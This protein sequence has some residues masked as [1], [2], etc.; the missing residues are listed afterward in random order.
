MGVLQLFS[1]AVEFW[2]DPRCFFQMAL[3]CYKCPDLQACSAENIL[4]LVVSSCWSWCQGGYW[5]CLTPGIEL[6]SASGP[7]FLPS[8]SL[9][10]FLGIFV[11]F[12][13]YQTENLT[14]NFSIAYDS[15]ISDAKTW[16]HEIFATLFT[17]KKT[18]LYTFLCLELLCCFVIP[19]NTT[20]I[21]SCLALPLY[22]WYIIMLV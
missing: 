11:C 18:T 2:R 19:G 10:V 1:I 13:W 12:P 22:F 17:L 15:F 8:V 6:W 9:P 5:Q 20:R 7:I 3:R 14:P 16:R 21:S 4:H